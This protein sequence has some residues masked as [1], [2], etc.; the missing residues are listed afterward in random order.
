MSTNST[1]VAS[2]PITNGQTK[3]RSIRKKTD[4]TPQATQSAAVVSTDQVRVSISTTSSQP[5]PPVIASTPAPSPVEP[6]KKRQ[7]TKKA[8]VAPIDTAPVQPIPEQTN[9]VK[10]EKK[11]RA[12]KSA[13]QDASTTSTSTSIDSTK[14]P[15][16]KQEDNSKAEAVE[17]EKRY[18]RRIDPTTGVESGRY[19]KLPHLAALKA[20]TR[21]NRDKAKT[22][23][24]IPENVSYQIFMKESTRGS[25]KQFYGYEIK[26][27][28]LTK[29]TVRKFK[30]KD[31]ATGEEVIREHEYT[32]K[33]NYKIIDV[34][35]SVVELNK[36]YKE[37]KKAEG[38]I[39]KKT[40]AEVLAASKLEAEDSSNIESD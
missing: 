35:A 23:D 9:G 12:P 30:S 19:S 20:F 5:I 33:N 15:V 24:P 18:F 29:S 2:A 6:K 10:P 3:K 13:T 16:A 39:N 38:N 27:N 32:H 26:L 25:T 7:P 22:S 34:P 11:K 31:K 40:K 21:I 37:Q 14:A 17:D 36:A 4:V 8:E 1:V 28:K